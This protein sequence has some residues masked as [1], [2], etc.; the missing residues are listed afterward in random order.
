MVDVANI[1]DKDPVVGSALA[2]YVQQALPT[3]DYAG[4]T[5][6]TSAAGRVTVNHALGLTPLFTGFTWVTNANHYDYN[7]VAASST[8]LIFQFY[9]NG[10]STPAASGQTVVFDWL[11]IA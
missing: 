11:V 2:Q 3:M 5:G 4:V 10:T 6:I 8:Q 7:L 1:G 9:A